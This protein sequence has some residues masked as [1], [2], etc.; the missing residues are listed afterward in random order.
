MEENKK[1]C[2]NCGK[3]P[4]FTINGE[5]HVKATVQELDKILDELN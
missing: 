5:V 4:V 2:E 3:G 1:C